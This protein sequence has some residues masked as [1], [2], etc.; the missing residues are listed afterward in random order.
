M[1]VRTTLNCRRWSRCLSRLLKKSNR[2]FAINCIVFWSRSKQSKQG[3]RKAITKC[4]ANSIRNKLKHWHQ[5]LVSWRS[6]NVKYKL[7]RTSFLN[8]NR[9]CQSLIGHS[10]SPPHETRNQVKKWH[11]T[12]CRLMSAKN[13]KSCFASTSASTLKSTK[14][15]A[16]AAA[17]PQSWT[18]KTTS[19]RHHP[20]RTL[21]AWH[22]CRVSS[23]M[24]RK[25]CNR[26][27]IRTT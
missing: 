4:R 19:P 13:W 8:R 22:C 12:N 23:S 26:R 7:I 24:S 5:G 1:L 16:F 6:R 27:K 20:K 17:E 11:W 2:G 15:Y 3:V 18:L 14:T 10:K 9:A 21:R 25:T